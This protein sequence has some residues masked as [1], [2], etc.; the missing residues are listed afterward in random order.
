MKYAMQI[1]PLAAQSVRDWFQTRGGVIMWI[2]REIGHDRPEIITPNLDPRGN[3]T[4]APHWAYGDC[5]HLSPG[6]IGI[7][8]RADIVPP[9]SW[10][11]KCI[12]CHGKGRLPIKRLAQAR[13]CSI[14]DASH[15]LVSQGIEIFPIDVSYTCTYC[16]GTGHVERYIRVAVRRK[17]WGYELTKTGKTRAERYCADLQKLQPE[18]SPEVMYDW[19]HCGRGLAELCFYTEKLTPFTL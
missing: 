7:V 19:N 11:P 18:G 17:Y 6:L 12:Q 3:L 10:F 1:P 16:Q 8:D 4:D 9:A 13:S 2:N 14:V 15:L 5:L